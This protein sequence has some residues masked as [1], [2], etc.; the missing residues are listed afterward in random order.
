MALCTQ[1]PVSLYTRTEFCVLLLFFRCTRRPQSA[2][3]PD[4]LLGQGRGEYD[5][6]EHD[7]ELRNQNMYHLPNPRIELFKKSPLYQLP[8]CWNALDETKYHQNKTTFTIALK[9]KLIDEINPN[10]IYS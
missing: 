4:N 6:R 1:Y 8:L 5:I 9:D 2:H 10:H 7:H 3:L